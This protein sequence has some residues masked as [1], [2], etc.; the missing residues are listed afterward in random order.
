[1]IFGKKA[2]EAKAAS[3]LSN[4]GY[5]SKPIIDP[6]DPINKRFLVPLPEKIDTVRIS[7]ISDVKTVWKKGL[8]EIEQIFEQHLTRICDMFED[9]TLEYE[10]VRQQLVTNHEFLNRYY[11]D[12]QR[13]LN[14]KHDAI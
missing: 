12:M 3:V 2:E 10:T 9:K 7:S 8:R 1:M 4:S 11:L 5:D 6:S 13:K 14:D